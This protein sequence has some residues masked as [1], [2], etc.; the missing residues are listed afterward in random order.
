[1]PQPEYGLPAPSAVVP[2]N[3][4]LMCARLTGARYLVGRL[5]GCLVGYLVGYLVVGY[6]VGRLVGRRQSLFDVEPGG[7]LV[8]LGQDTQLN[9]LEQEE[10][11]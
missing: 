5:V 11:R 9:A 4:L 8:P 7:E 1:M 3:G 6:L 2:E 10:Q